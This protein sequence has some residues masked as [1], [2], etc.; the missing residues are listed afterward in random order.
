MAASGNPLGN[1]HEREDDPMSALAKPWQAAGGQLARG[2]DAEQARASLRQ[3]L[4]ELQEAL[5]VLPER[6]LAAE[7]SHVALRGQR[8]QTGRAEETERG[9]GPAPV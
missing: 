1:E 5:A 3:C 9:F 8:M 7:R 6:V 4:H 2:V